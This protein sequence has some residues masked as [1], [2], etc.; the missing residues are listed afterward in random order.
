MRM[1]VC[2]PRT[3]AAA[4]DG[5]RP[6]T[7][8]PSSVQARVRARMAVVFPAP[9]GAIASC[10]RAPGGAHLADQRGL[11]GIQGGAVRRHLQQRQIHRR[12]DRR[13][14]RRGVR[15]R[16]RGAARRRGSAARC[17]GRRRRRCRPT[18]RRPAATPPVPRCRQR[19]GEGNRSAIEHLID[20]QIHQRARPLCRHV[21]RC[22]PVVVLRRG[23]ATS[24][25]SSGSPP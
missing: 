19:R 7:W 2:S 23:H 3:A 13:L 22:G 11:P 5:A 20:Q 6:S 4:A 9:A 10:S 25:R 24:A 17:R 8:P 12:L 15:R 21:G 18:T 1:P 14:S 16:R